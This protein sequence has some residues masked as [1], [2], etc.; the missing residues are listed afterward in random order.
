MRTIEALSIETVEQATITPGAGQIA[1]HP[2]Q[3]PAPFFDLRPY[4][5]ALL[6]GLYAAWAEDA[7]RVLLQLPTGGGKTVLLAK[8]IEQN[9]ARGQTCLV[10]VHREELLTQTIAKVEAITGQAPGAI[11]AGYRPDHSSPVQVASIQTLVN[12]LDAC[13]QFDVVIFDE[14]HHS[15]SQTWRRVFEAFPHAVV[16]GVT[17][18]PIRT[19]GSG[20]R[21]LFD[22]LICGVSMADLIDQWHLSPYRYFAPA[23]G[24]NLQGLRVRGGD[25]T[26]ESIE[27]QNS[28]A[29]VAADCLK[30]YA[31]YCQGQRVL[32]FASS[33]AYSREIAIAFSTQGIPAAHLDG[34]DEP[35]LRATT[36]EAFRAGAIQVLSNCAL[37]TEGLD[38]PGID[39]VILARPTKSLGLWLQMVGRALRPAPGKELATIIDLGSNWERFGLPADDRLWSLDGIEKKPRAKLVKDKNGAIVEEPEP[40]ILTV[41]AGPSNIRLMEVKAT[42]TA[43]LGET[44]RQAWVSRLEQL[45]AIAKERNYKPGWL[46][47]RLAELKPPLEIWRKVG[48]K[49][50]FKPGWAFHKHREHTLGIQPVP[51]EEAS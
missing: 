32:V 17:A 34:K 26:R 14:A 41:T 47:Y 11:K 12:R 37:F 42:T 24:L 7:W 43:S 10:V 21:D 48:K 40:E 22:R 45:E 25:Y 29:D 39:G 31:D 51:K 2:S 23:K 3:A 15:C 30:A 27:Q 4:Q 36:M 6:D 46:T 44:E 13:P 5:T 19:D 8:V 49:L 33:V 38:V 1:L 20:F 28:A 18:T 9:L 35:E 16:L 50:G